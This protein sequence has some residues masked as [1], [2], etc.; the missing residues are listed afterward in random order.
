VTAGDEGDDEFFEQRPLTD[1]CGFEVFDQASEG[2][3]GRVEGL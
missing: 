2:L 1:N 3:A